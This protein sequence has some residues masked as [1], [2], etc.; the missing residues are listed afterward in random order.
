MSDM[1]SQEIVRRAIEFD[2]P[3]RL[4]MRFG[5]LGVSDT[6]GVG[7]GQ[8]GTGYGSGERSTVDEWHCRWQRTEVANMGQVK[9]HPLADLAGMADFPWPDADDPALYEGMEQRF[10]GAE[11]KYVT[12]GIFMLLFERM[13]AL[14]GFEQTLMALY[15][16]RA[17]MEALADRIVRFDL[18]IIRNISGRFGGRIHGFSFTDDWGTERATFIDPALW[19]DFFAP[20][21]KRIFDACHDAGWHVWMHTCGKVN[22]IIEILI[23]IGLD[24]INLQQPRALGIEQIG[25]QFRGR[26]CFESL[27]DIQATLPFKDAHAIGEEAAELL[28]MYFGIVEKL[29]DYFA[30]Q[31]RT[32]RN[33]HKVYNIFDRRRLFWGVET[34]KHF[35]G[36]KRQMGHVYRESYNFPVQSSASDIHSLAT[37]RL[38]RDEWLRDNEAWIVASIHDSVMLEVDE[39]KAEEVARYVQELMRRTAH[40]A[41][42]RIGRPWI[43][44]VDV[45]WGPRW[46]VVTHKLHSDG[47]LEVMK[48]KAA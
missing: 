2:D 34:M 16:D 3:P 7:W 24:V 43:V 11:G 9:G 47:T 18:G 32:V 46:E 41:T 23:G 4:P 30:R 8:V 19:D 17:R 44:P 27:C 33:R 39:A 40:E 22:G 20:R 31:R 1:T 37:I 12:T 21:Y 29:P 25:R 38:D 48:E 26:I 5:S 42:A 15:A 13:H 10:E 14:A 6:H 28:D 45:E 35:G 36:Y